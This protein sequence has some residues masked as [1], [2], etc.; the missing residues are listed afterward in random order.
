MTSQLFGWLT[1]RVAHYVYI[2]GTTKTNEMRRARAYRA[3][4]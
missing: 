4:Y 1:K 3:Y 2:L